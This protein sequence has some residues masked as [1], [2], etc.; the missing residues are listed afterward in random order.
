MTYIEF[1][2]IIYIWNEDGGTKH[3]TKLRFEMLVQRRYKKMFTLYSYRHTRQK[4]G[5]DLIEES[6]TS[7]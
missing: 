2:F 7:D 5:G 3:S 4:E 1:F 6:S